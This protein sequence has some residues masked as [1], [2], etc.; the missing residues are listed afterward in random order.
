MWWKKLI[1]KYAFIFV[2]G[3]F[4]S[5]IIILRFTSKLTGPLVPGDIIIRFDNGIAYYPF[6][7]STVFGIATIIATEV[8]YFTLK[9]ARR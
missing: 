1:A 2:L 7:T 4:G 6:G 3:F 9:K 5:F 8:Y